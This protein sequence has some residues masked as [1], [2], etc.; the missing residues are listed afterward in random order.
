MSQEI[1]AIWTDVLKVLEDELSRPS[2]DAWLKTSAPV[3]VA[4]DAVEVPVPHDFARDWLETRY[5]AML[6]ETM[7][8]M[9]GRDVTVR[10]VAREGSTTEE[11]A[12][13]E[14]Q[15][16][17]A[18]RGQV[19]HVESAHQQKGVPYAYEPGSSRGIGVIEAAATAGV[20]TQTSSEYQAFDDFPPPSLNSK[21][22]FESFV[23]G[24]SNRFAHAAALAVSEAP[25]KAYNPFFI[26]GGVGLGKTHLMQAIGHHVLELNPYA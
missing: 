18:S 4:D 6:S 1:S 16:P 10:F 2:F 25:G 7:S 3:V 23:V 8:A 13:A 20:H 9:V 22:T 21:Y 24:N 5:A 15:A 14:E 19:R 17:G 11:N 26:Y 12:D